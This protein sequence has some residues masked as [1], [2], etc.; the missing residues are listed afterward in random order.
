MLTRVSEQPDLYISVDVEA[1][2]PIPGPYSMLSFGLAV[3]GRYDGKRFVAADPSNATYYVEMRPI[4]DDFDPDALAVS[5]LDRQMLARDGRDPTDAMNEAAEWVRARTGND[6][7]VAVGFPLIYDWMFLYW[8]FERFARD[9][10]PF[11][12]S[13]GLDMKTM[14]QQKSGAVLSDS[15]KDSLPAHLRGVAPHRHQA[16]DDAV[17]QAGIFARLFTWD[18]R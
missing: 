12:F 14:Y 16:L 7:P 13:S 17:E 6:R 5:G 18:G 10:S 15:G 3:A 1:D 9:G 11:G 8:Y 4:S 2:G